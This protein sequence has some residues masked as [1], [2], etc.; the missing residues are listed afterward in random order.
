[1]ANLLVSD[2]VAYQGPGTT[3]AGPTV[4]A[5]QDATL[6]STWSTGGD[7][8]NVFS[9]F[10]AIEGRTPGLDHGQES[11]STG[12][13]NPAV[14]GTNVQ[15]AAT[16]QRSV[17]TQT[18]FGATLG[19][20]NISSADYGCAQLPGLATTS[21]ALGQPSRSSGTA[22]IRQAHTGVGTRGL[23]VSRAT[24]AVPGPGS[25]TYPAGATASPRE[26]LN[27]LIPARAATCQVF[28]E[29]LDDLAADSALWRV[30]EG[31][32]TVM[33]PTVSADRLK[34]SGNPVSQIDRRL[35]SS[36]C[37]GGLAV[38]GLAAAIWVRDAGA[39][40]ARKRR[41]GGYLR[42]SHSE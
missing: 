34:L 5:L 20:L 15:D 42:T 36:E 9:V 4:G 8:S 24:A 26:A 12:A 40:D 35:S 16:S 29:V 2:L 25:S 13:L 11:G 18:T 6:S 39:I 7:I 10:N 21:G 41:S 28:D 27:E 17:T 31:Y 3:Y 22:T 23:A 1:M 33:T 14:N 32:G 30:Q 19:L 38:L 37:A